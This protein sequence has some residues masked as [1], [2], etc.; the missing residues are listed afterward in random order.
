LV[1]GITET[2]TR[3]LRAVAKEIIDPSNHK[4][5]ETS[6]QETSNKGRGK[7]TYKKSQKNGLFPNTGTAI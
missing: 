4:N 5:L 2:P 3:K 6:V 1:V 7:N